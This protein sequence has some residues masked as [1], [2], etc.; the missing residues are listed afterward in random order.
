MPDEIQPEITNQFAIVHSA[1][2]WLPQ[3]LTWLFNLVCHLP[4]EIECH[5]VCHSTANL[6][7]FG[8]R[9]IHSLSE[10]RPVR[11]SVRTALKKVGLWHSGYFL[12]GH[13]ERCGAA[14]LHS[15]FGNRGWENLWAARRSRLRHVVSFY[16]FDVNYLPMNYPIWRN[17]YHELFDSV[18]C[19]LCEGRF[20]AQAV[21]QL[22]CPLDRIRI[23]HLGIPVEQLPFKPRTWNPSDP[24]CVLIAASFQEKKGIPYALE[25]LGRLQH[26]VDLKIT[27]IGDANDEERS[28]REKQVILNT[29]E[30]Q[31]LGLRTRLLSYQPYDSLIK[32]AYRNHIFLSP[33]VTAHDGDT[34]GGLPVTILEMAATGMMVVSTRHCD[35]PEAIHSGTTGLLTEERDVDGILSHMRW[36]LNNPDKWHEMARASRQHVGREYD[37]RKQ[38]LRLGQIY[39][40]L[41]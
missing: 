31:G 33:S 30:K 8:V 20:M 16:G 14:I 21:Q 32:E 23:Q 35:I 7:Q 12:H 27:I 38:A 4:P 15:H 25:A 36:L 3:T 1:L 28:Q 29:I 22:G 39:K 24:L 5:V 26:E 19:V 10:D 18:D 37:V 41:I 6:D 2:V 40:E 9:H 13:I 11:R 17:R 34:E